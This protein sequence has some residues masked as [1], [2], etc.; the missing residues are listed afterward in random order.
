MP[1]RTP[2]LLAQLRSVCDGKANLDSAQSGQY[3]HVSQERLY[4]LVR[5]KRLHPV[6]WKGFLIFSRGD[7]DRYRA[8]LREYELTTAFVQGE[9]P[10]DV[11]LRLQ[12]RYS[13]REVNRVLMDWARL[14]G[15]WLIEAPRGSYARWLQR[16][17]IVAISPRAVRRL[18]EALLTDERIGELARSYVR[19]QRGLNGL[20]EA[21]KQERAR[22]RGLRYEPATDRA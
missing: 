21:K 12:G 14:T 17:Q 16:M 11:F 22:R 2:Q 7:L 13:L 6:S 15:V 5:E 4:G 19:D 3:L 18:I 8:E 1:A 10:I 9:H 20:G